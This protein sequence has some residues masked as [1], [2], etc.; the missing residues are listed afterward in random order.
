MHADRFRWSDLG[1]PRKSAAGST[2]ISGDADDSEGVGSEGK[3]AEGKGG[4]AAVEEEVHVFLPALPSSLKIPQ[5]DH[6]CCSRCSLTLPTETE[7]ESEDVSKQKVEPM[8][9]LGNSG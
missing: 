9:T 2:A 3:G 8:L 4:E 7:V 5:K 6:I 1:R